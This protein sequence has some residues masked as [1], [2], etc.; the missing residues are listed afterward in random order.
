MCQFFLAKYRVRI[1]HGGILLLLILF[2]L[3]LFYYVSNFFPGQHFK[4]SLT[5]FFKKKKL[6]YEKTAMAT[7]ISLIYL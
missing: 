5:L 3:I 6:A 4:L 1:C 2:L 7:K